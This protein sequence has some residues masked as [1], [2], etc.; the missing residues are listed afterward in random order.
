MALYPNAADPG[1]WQSFVLREDVKTLPVSEQR[2]KYL[3][4]QLQFEDF[5]A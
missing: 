2:K 1:N 4:E 5:M 3:T